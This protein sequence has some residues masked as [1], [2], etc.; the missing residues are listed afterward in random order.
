M[1][2]MIQKIIVLGSATVDLIFKGKIFDER[3]VKN[4]LSLALGGKY[5]VDEFYQYFGGGGANAAI[6]LARQGFKVLLISKVGK[7]IFGKRIKDNLKKEK[8][9]TNLLMNTA[10]ATQTSSILIN[11]AGKRTIV[12][13][14][15]DADLVDLTRKIK[16]KVKEAN[17]FVIF[18]LAKLSK[19]KKLKFLR[20][21]KQN[22]SKIFLSLH[23]TEYFKGF[24]YLRDYFRITDVMHMNAHECADIFGG[25]AEN[26]DYHKVNFC[27]KLGVPLLVVSY[28]VKG[29][30]A[31]TKD[32]IYH[33]PI[34]DTKKIVDTTGAGDAFA[35]GFLGKYIKT[36]DIKAS[37]EFATKNATSVIGHLGAQNGLLFDRR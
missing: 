29:S 25:N 34:I 9:R 16:K 23:G 18:S 17:W 12:N 32:K 35:S 24:D 28:D 22:G 13:F 1:K 5:V 8:V 15:G 6:S 4:R 33:Q 14:R 37:L 2:N 21:A 3:E 26:F 11:S 27:K 20:L 7:D 31:Y 30:F 19:E 10:T 36:N